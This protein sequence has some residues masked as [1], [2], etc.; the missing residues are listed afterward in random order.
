MRLPLKGTVSPVGKVITYFYHV[1]LLLLRKR[2]APCT[3]QLQQH[4]LR[5]VTSPRRSTV[6]AI[7][8]HRRKG[9]SVVT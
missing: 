2:V 6:P 3:V 7:Q 8:V 9:I 1:F 5:V 4:F